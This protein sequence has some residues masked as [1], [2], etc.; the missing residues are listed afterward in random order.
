MT[1]LQTKYEKKTKNLVS[2][3]KFKG[4]YFQYE[5]LSERP[6]INDNSSLGLPKDILSFMD[7]ETI[8]TFG[9]FYK[10]GLKEINFAYC[11][12]KKINYRKR[13]NKKRQPRTLTFPNISF[14]ESLS[15]IN[16]QNH[17]ELVT[18]LDIDCFTFSIL[19]LIT[20]TDI[21]R[22]INV[23]NYLFKLFSNISKKNYNINEFIDFLKNFV[24]NPNFENNN[25]EVTIPRILL[26]N[27]DEKPK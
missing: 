18:T 14:S 3:F 27:V 6:E 9:V 26:V 16:R 13:T 8:G 17:F 20:G 24:N 23:L 15:Q 5:L 10:D 1:F 19:N 11:S 12:A 21:V 2:P 4:E 7:Y 25:E 22:N